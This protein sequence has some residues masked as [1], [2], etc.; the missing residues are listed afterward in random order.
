M[1]IHVAVASSDGVTVN[2]HFGRAD[3]FRIYRVT[4]E[5]AEFLEERVNA[6]ACS[7]QQH[8]D[9]LLERS[10]ELIS[11]CKA[12]IAAQIGPGAIDILLYRRIRAFPLT[13]S[14]DEAITTL[15]TSRRFLYLK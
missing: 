9:S 13:G 3:R 11:D 2:L 6:P 15:R 7:G 8:D 1:D 12:V 5:A 14:I 10:A 4:D